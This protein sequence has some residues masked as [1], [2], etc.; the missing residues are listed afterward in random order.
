MTG[1]DSGRH[2][3]VH[4]RTA[5]TRTGERA[6]PGRGRARGTRGTPGGASGEPGAA[7]GRSLT[8]RLL[9][10]VIPAVLGLITGLY[11]LGVPPLWRD[12]AATKAIAS[13][14]VGQILATMPHDDVVHGAYY[15]VV[16]AFIGLF[17][18]SNGTLRLPSAIAAAVACAFTALV[19][20]RLAADGGRWYSALT[21]VTA[22]AVL[23]L[24]PAMIRYAQ[25]ARSYAIV[26]M[27]AAIA[28]YLLLRAI[29]GGRPGWWAAYGAA[30]FLT[31]LFNIF[32]LLIVVAHGLTLLAIGW[33]GSAG[34]APAG[35]YYG[36]DFDSPAASPASPASPAQSRGRRL[37]G[38][39]V[40]W[41]AA[42]LAAAVL[43]VPLVAM[44][45]AQ[46]NALSW[47]S[48]SAPVGRDTVALAH[49]WA[50]SPGL[51]W[52]VFGLAGLGAVAS[53]IAGGRS[54]SPA[55]VALPWLIAP[56]AIL[57]AVS[58]THP[59]YDQRYVEFC[60]P[61]LAILA[62]AG[63]TWLWRAAALGLGRLTSGG[64]G[65]AGWLAC[66]PAVAAAVALAVALQPADAVVRQPSYRPDNLENEAQIIAANYKPGDIVFFIPL[67]DRIVSMPFPGPWQKL[68]DIALADSPASSDTLYG[69]DV[70]P[71]ELQQRFTQVT[72]VWVVSSS[73]VPEATYLASAQA[74]P[75]DKEEFALAGAMRKVHRWRDGDTEL[76]LY[77]AR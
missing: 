73:E 37:L 63:I 49:L 15:L 10:P 14:P 60:L 32:G 17:G 29:D 18:S 20:R 64:P 74:T 13:R 8:E 70:S 59:V 51:V 26:T 4:A 12:E 6:V 52:P 2:R 11:H 28:T 77:A 41:L 66:L 65:A 9:I 19:A 36:A 54:L 53:V 42:G 35:P 23:A 68:R 27:L 72:R 22:G 30:V 1:V 40:G 39:P 76:T 45:Y 3:G 33:R 75:L 21:G 38:V 57:L 46:R 61:G 43:L 31:G 58:T 47:M 16:H 34:R 25:E 44:A 71:A 55:T 24:L 62:A 69:T 67:N 50:G 48:A 56:P 7:A 5:A